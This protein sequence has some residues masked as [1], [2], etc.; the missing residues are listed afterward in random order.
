M[1]RGVVV[2]VAWLLLAPAAG[3][4][5]TQTL[6]MPEPAGEYRALIIGIDA[7]R[8]VPKLSTAVRDAVAVRDVLIQRYGFKRERIAEL[9]NDQATRV[10]IE[11]ALFRLAQDAGVNDSVFIYYAGHGQ[12]DPDKV[13]GWWVPVE[14][15][16]TS[17]G[18]MINNASIRDAIQAMK[19]RHVYLVA[20]SC[21]S[22]TLFAKTRSLP[23]L[24]DKFFS[25]LYETKSRWG[26]TSG[27]NEP[28]A[29][30]GKGGHSIFAYFFLKLLQ[31]N[32]DPYLVPSQIYARIAPLVGRN[33]DQVP[34][35]EPLQGAG[36]E[37]GQFV[38]RLVRAVPSRGEPPA[39]SET[40]AALRQA[41]EELKKLEE[42]ER[43]VQE[44]A[45]LKAL[46][47]QIADKKKSIEAARRDAALPPLPPGQRQIQG[48]GLSLM[49]QLLDRAR[50]ISDDDWPAQK[51]Q[52]LARLDREM[53]ARG[54]ADPMARRRAL[55]EIMSILE[56][57]R[58][59]PAD[60]Y[61]TLKPR[62]AARMQQI[63]T[64]AGVAR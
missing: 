52:M 45:K 32:Q 7:Y 3:L 9:L 13:R 8:H 4:A 18:T 27:M 49:V 19:A 55:F 16:E 56:D 44:Q 35:S 30:S 6:G 15:R 31:E 24:D 41:E 40:S 64:N 1:R 51:R 20:D 5:Q 63:S 47:E 22:G 60:R 46:R 37:G 26:F 62:L 53:T 43:Q 14:G 10:N 33:A 12:T 17:P 34:Q 28:V 39:T 50:E 61:P 11:D 58:R 36:D 23:P 29:D 59:V 57:A 21:F 38:F 2:A 25:R 48:D 42:Q 54:V